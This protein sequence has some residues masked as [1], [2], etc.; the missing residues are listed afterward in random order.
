MP[1]YPRLRADLVSSRQIVGGQ[2]VYTVKDPITERYFRLRQPEFW[3]INRLDGETSPEEIA[4]RFKEKFKLNIAAEDVQKFVDRLEELLFLE[5]SRSEQSLSRASCRVA[6]KPSLASRIFFLKLKVFNPEKLIDRLAALYNPFHRRFWFIM[7]G[8][9]VVIG[10]SIVW[11]NAGQFR[12]DI[13]KLFN[14]SSLAAVIFSLFVLIS[15]HELAHGVI[16]RHYG[17]RVTDVGFLLMYFQPCFYCNVS[18]AW[19]FEKKSHRLA[20]TWAGPYFQLILLAFAAVVWRLTVPGTG[21]N[22]IAR[23]VVIVSWLSYLFNFNPLIKL[24]GYY[25]LSDWLDIP[26]LRKKSFAYLGNVVRRRLLGWPVKA[27][28]IAGREKRIFLTYAVFALLYTGFLIGYVLFLVGGFLVTRLGGVGLLLLIAV[29]FL[30]FRQAVAALMHGTVRHIVHMKQLLRKPF[31]L[32]GYLAVFLLVLIGGLTVPFPHRVSGEIIVNPIS[33]F[34][35]SLN[36]F[37]LLES[38][39]HQGGAQP[40]SKL[41]FLQMTANDMTVLDLTPLVRDGQGVNPGDTVAILTSNQITREIAT[42]QAEL[43]KLQE[44]LNLLKAPPKKEEVAEATAQVN[45][46]RASYDQFVRAYERIEKLVGKNLDAPE[47]LEAAGAAVDIARAELA[48]K[49]SSLELL[50]S[51]PRPE[52]EAVLVHKVQKQKVYLDYLEQQADA[53]RIVAPIGGTVHT[54]AEDNE[55]LQISDNRTVELMVP[56]SD[57][58]ITLIQIGQH[59]RV[60]VRSYPGRIF[61]GTVVRIPKAVET[62]REGTSFPVSVVIDNTDDLLHE[63]MSGYA[64]IEVGKSSLVNLGVRKLMSLLRVEFWSLW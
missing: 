25:L 61:S 54:R 27:L 28:S 43:N 60:K 18:D 59:V 6:A 23:I 29:L 21:I 14:I 35:L 9:L 10:L 49:T 58:D 12:V 30:I 32:A 5:N 15:L 52:E 38:N 8:L 2:Q 1:D 36:D 17:G 37:G 53:Q 20:V 26:N 7:Q 44:E 13:D 3:L 64:K 48:N 33:R 42:G 47:K 19:L 57:F 41:S 45:A 39:L 24:D 31:R 4:D 11:A 16:C 56:V 55:I 50:K 40:E 62:Y 34:T 46:A 51:P 63:G 22:L